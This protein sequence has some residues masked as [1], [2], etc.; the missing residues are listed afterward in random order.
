MAENRMSSL[1]YTI[2]SS[3]NVFV[4]DQQGPRQMNSGATL[5][6]DSRLKLAGMTGKI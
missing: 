1:E 6:F 5:S 2:M 4:G 3:P